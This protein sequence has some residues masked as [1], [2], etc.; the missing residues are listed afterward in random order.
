MQTSGTNLFYQ[1]HRPGLELLSRRHIRE[2]MPLCVSVIEMDRWG[3]G[4]RLPVCLEC[5]GRYGV[6]AKAALPQLREAFRRTPEWTAKNYRK[7]FAKAIADV[8][9]RMDAPKLTSLQEF[10]AHA[11]AHRDA[12]PSVKKGTP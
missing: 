1:C 5:L 8:E 12:S 2:G 6:H 3:E 9:A 11:S 4:D 7:T 10:I